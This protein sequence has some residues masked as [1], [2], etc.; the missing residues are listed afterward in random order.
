MIN[1]NNDNNRDCET[2]CWRKLPVFKKAITLLKLVE[3]LIDGISIEESGANTAYQVA[4]YEHHSK[5]LMENALIIPVKIAGAEGDDIYDHKMENATVIRKAA[6][7]MLIDTTGLQI[8]GFNEVEYLDVLRQEIEA[9]RPIFAE[10]IKTFNTENYII[11]RWG[12]FN[13]PG[14]NYNDPEDIEDLF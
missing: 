8:A 12:L 2:E 3:Q 4:M 6:K 7:E 13:P 11:D 5:S 1:D 14:I 10:W 9:F